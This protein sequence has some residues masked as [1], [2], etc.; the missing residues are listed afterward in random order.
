MG[1]DRSAIRTLLQEYV[2]GSFSPDAVEQAMSCLEPFFTRADKGVYDLCKK[3]ELPDLLIAF[4]FVEATDRPV[5]PGAKLEYVSFKELEAKAEGKSESENKAVWDKAVTD[6]CPRFRQ[7]IARAFNEKLDAF[8]GP[9]MRQRMDDILWPAL[10]E[11]LWHSFENNYWDSASH[12]F[13]ME[14]RATIL[15]AIE[16]F[17]GFCVA[18]EASHMAKLTVIV[19]TLPYAIVLGRLEGKEDTFITLVD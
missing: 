12:L 5:P 9:V 6:A 15:E 1:T 10:A 11:P 16:L 7:E 17:V 14:V 13:K 2:P 4:S 8:L 19:N 3:G 18:G